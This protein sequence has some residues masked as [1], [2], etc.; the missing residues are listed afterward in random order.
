[1]GVLGDPAHGVFYVAEEAG[2]GQELIVARLEQL[3]SRELRQ[4]V[5]D[6]HSLPIPSDDEVR[7][8]TDFIPR[9]RQ[10]M[11]ITSADRSV[12]LP[13]YIEP[14][15]GVVVHFRPEH[16]VRLDW[17][18]HYDAPE[19]STTYPIDDPPEP[20]SIRDLAEEQRKLAALPLPYADIPQLAEHSKEPPH[21]PAAHVL[22]D[23][24]PA[25]Q[26]VEQVLPQ[27]APA[28]VRVRLEGEIREYRKTNSQ[29][30]VQVAAVERA[31]SADWFDLHIKVAID[32]EEVPFEDLF[33]ALTQGQDFLILETG[34]YFSLER[35][36]FAQLRALIEE[37]KALQ[38]RLGGRKPYAV[39]SVGPRAT[40]LGLRKP[41]RQSSGRTNWMDTAGCIS[42]GHTNLAASL[43]T[44]WVWV[45]PCKRSRSSAM[46]G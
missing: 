35:P 15:V 18:V 6:P 37:S 27:L 39:S 29:P 5:V 41:C 4:L 33:V 44:I 26:F 25:L 38:D 46:P 32:G 10:K 45:R 13:D 3:L 19:G 9:L 40:T 31:N 14:T 21:R 43:P 8:L 12:R 20:R 11:M 1:V 34:V 28:G 16:R 7:F 2:S 30:T 22:L 23:G 24:L 36:E 17:V 42:C